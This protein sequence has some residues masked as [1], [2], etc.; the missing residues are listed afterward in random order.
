MSW[1]ILLLYGENYIRVHHT[2][3]EILVTI[4]KF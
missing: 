3:K 2:E 1:R 4:A